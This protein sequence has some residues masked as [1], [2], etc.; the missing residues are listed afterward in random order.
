V[1]GTLLW[2]YQDE[3]ANGAHGR[4]AGESSRAANKRT[5]VFAGRG[6]GHGVDKCKLV[7]MVEVSLEQM[8][9]ELL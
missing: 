9:D 3:D 5:S 1:L 2:H 4:G 7:K 8:V 6:T